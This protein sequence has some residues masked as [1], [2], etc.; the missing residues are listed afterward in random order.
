MNIGKQSKT[1]NKS[2]IEIVRSF[3]RSKRNGIRNE[4]IFLLS[5]KSGMRSKEISRLSWKMSVKSDGSLDDNIHLTNSS[6]KYNGGRIIPIHKD[7]KKNLSILYEDH[8]KLKSFNIDTSFVVRTERS[9]FTT[10]QNIFFNHVNDIRFNY[11]EINFLF[12]LIFLK[13]YYTHQVFQKNLINFLV[14]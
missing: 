2:Q 4:T 9:P 8:K 14:L 10:S 7:L 5:V 13:N 1:L 3:F 11:K 6:S 12:N